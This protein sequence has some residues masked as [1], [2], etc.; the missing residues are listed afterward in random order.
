MPLMHS[1]RF[2]LALATAAFGAFAASAGFWANGAWAASIGEP[3]GAAVMGQPLNLSVPVLLHEGDDI[4]ARCVAAEVAFG[5]RR[6]PTSAV[7]AVLQVLSAQVARVRVQTL[8]ALDE[9]VVHLLLNVGCQPRLIRRFVVLADPPGLESESAAPAP[10]AVLAPA[11]PEASSPLASPVPGMTPSEAARRARQAAPEEPVARSAGQAAGSP[12]A[13]PAGQTGTRAAAATAPRL[14]LDSASR[15]E[16]P[17]GLGR[18]EMLVVEQAIRAVVEAASAVRAASSAASAAEMRAQALDRRLAQ[19]RAE[20][21]TQRE[22]AA[23]MRERLAQSEASTRWLWPLAAGLVLLGALAGWLA[24]QLA[25]L[26]R[27]QQRGWQQAAPVGNAPPGVDEGLVHEPPAAATPFVTLPLTA[28]LGRVPAGLAAGAPVAPAKHQATPAWPPPAP[29]EPAPDS[30]ADDGFAV[31][32]Q[33]GLADR[34]PVPA[35]QRTLPLPAGDRGSPTQ[36]ATRD[37]SIEEL[38]DL[39]QQADFFVVLG[40]D[41]AAIDLLVE[42]L[43]STGGGSPLPY[44]KLLEI[45]HRRGDRDAYERTRTRFNQR[46]NAYVGDWSTGLQQ[47]RSLEDYPDVMPRLVQVWPRP[48]QAMAELEALLFRKPLG[49]LFDLPAYREVLFLYAL[50]RELHDRETAGSGFGDIDLLLPLTDGG[51]FGATAP[52]PYF[53]L[54]RGSVFDGQA[55]DDTPTSPVDLDL[56]QADVQRASIFDPLAAR[57]RVP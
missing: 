51:E 11:L 22:A 13:R 54:D 44:L 45:Y 50:A 5:E 38:I 37:L 12:P 18:T 31:S 28:V 14:T 8:S 49:E 10:P 25:A 33:P 40:Q 47:G 6:L 56:T 26:R 16:E 24:W 32:T 53:G 19:L 20:N 23:L 42:H 29:A 15:P 4:D 41:D 55:A 21:Q 1:K 46:F 7:T 3:G 27:E 34:E 35:M 2:G 39:E 57:R 36:E 30:P 52:H 9:P 48:T 17:A 43:R